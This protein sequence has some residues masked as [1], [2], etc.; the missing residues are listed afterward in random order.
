MMHI[1]GVVLNEFISHRAT[2]QLC[3]TEVCLPKEGETVVVNG[4]AGAV[5]SIVGQIAKIKGCRVVG[6]QRLLIP[7]FFT[8]VHLHMLFLTYLHPTVAVHT[9]IYTHICDCLCENRPYW[10]I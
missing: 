2:A 7:Y 10:H 1:N 4:A 6:E 9:N 8:F 3:F 5:G